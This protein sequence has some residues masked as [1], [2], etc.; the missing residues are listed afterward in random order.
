MPI[1][2]NP[3]FERVIRSHIRRVSR[4]ARASA[5]RLHATNDTEAL[6]DFRVAVRRLRTWMA[7]FRGTAGIPR[8]TLR[9]WRRLARETNAARDREILLVWLKAQ[10][11]SSAPAQRAMLATL[12]RPRSRSERRLTRE[13]ID[14]LQERWS[15]RARQLAEINAALAVVTPAQWWRQVRRRARELQTALAAVGTHRD[16]Q[17]IHRARIC[18]K[19]VRYLLEPFRT[20]PDVATTINVL[21][22]LQDAFGKFN[23]L[24]VI[25]AL[26]GDLRAATPSESTR[27]EI[28]RLRRLAR[29]HQRDGFAE[30]RALPGQ[31]TETVA[32]AERIRRN[33]VLNRK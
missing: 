14:Q 26:L 10:R 19:H 25:A 28:D 17:Q 27:R 21:T 9:Q 15:R 31:T 1:N 7:A 12:I 3:G 33:T 4:Q 13:S 20:H 30:L 8:R 32:R 16:T 29:Q 5:R 6:H 23:D 11:R 2:G 24:T 22:E 18:A